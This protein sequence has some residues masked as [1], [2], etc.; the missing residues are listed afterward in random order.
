MDIVSEQCNLLVA[1]HNGILDK[2]QHSI[3]FPHT[4]SITFYTYF[5]SSVSILKSTQKGYISG[6]TREYPKGDTGI[7]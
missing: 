7:E 5:L 4:F 3:G 1:L 2:A 6:S